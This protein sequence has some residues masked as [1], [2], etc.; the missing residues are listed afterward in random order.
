MDP[1]LAVII[2]SD[3][4]DG[5][6]GDCLRS[7]ARQRNAPSFE[8]VVASASAPPPAGLPSPPAWVR[9]EDRNPALRRNRAVRES[10]GA[11]LAFLDDDAEAEPDWLEAGARALERCEIAGGPD[12]LRSGASY[13]ERLSDLLLATPWIGSG[14]PAHQRNPRRGPV[15]SAHD[16]ALCNLFVRRETFDALRGF[17]ESLGYISED[18]DFIRRALASGARVELDRAVRVRHRRRPFP[19]A[20]LAQRWRY[21]VKTGRMLVERPGLHARGRITAFLVAGFLLTA[22]AASF[23]SAVVV[24]ASLFYSGLVWALS[25]PIWRRDL[26]LFPAV[27]FAFVLHHA[28]Y[29]AGLLTGIVRGA[30]FLLRSARPDPAHTRGDT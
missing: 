13:A 3:R 11:L 15:R 7:L 24:P 22:G 18:T 26:A 12:L 17:D 10:R 1:R 29:F 20:Y 23:G 25:F 19:L 21:R 14:I 4:V 6:L 16:V 2:P 5:V 30:A 28:V 8:V 9:V 27:P